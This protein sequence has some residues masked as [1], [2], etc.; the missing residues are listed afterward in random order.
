MF[1]PQAVAQLGTL[2]SSYAPTC[3][4]GTPVSSACSTRS[5]RNLKT[6]D[7]DSD[8]NCMQGQ[9]QLRAR[10]TGIRAA[11]TISSKPK[12]IPQFQAAYIPPRL[13]HTQALA[14]SRRG[15]VSPPR[16]LPPVLVLLLFSATLDGVHL[17][18]LGS[19][20]VECLLLICWATIHHIKWLVSC[21]VTKS[22]RDKHSML[23]TRLDASIAS[24]DLGQQ[25]LSSFSRAGCK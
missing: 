22:V 20:H 18:A 4:N 13:W 24:G 3:G 14:S 5:R 10:S 15:T 23:S 16:M 9:S 8:L 6:R 19:G 1:T 2:T 21:I 25:Q 11:L 17:C 12:M 7:I